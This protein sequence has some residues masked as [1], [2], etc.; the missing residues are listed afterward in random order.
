MLLQLSA[1]GSKKSFAAHY[2]NS[3]YASEVGL[4]Q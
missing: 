1:S 3:E 2:L 4:G